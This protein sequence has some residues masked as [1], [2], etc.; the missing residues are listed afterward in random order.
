MIYAP[1]SVIEVGDSF[2]LTA[3]PR[4]GQGDVVPDAPIDWSTSDNS[5][6]SVHPDGLITALDVGIADVIA[7]PVACAAS[8][9]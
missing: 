5:V 4:D 7:S 1:P 3:S 2:R 6:L 9:R 8:S